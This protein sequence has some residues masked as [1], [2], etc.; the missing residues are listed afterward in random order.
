M[1]SF[2]TPAAFGISPNALWLAALLCALVPGSGSA[3]TPASPQGQPHAPRA[4][5]TSP[6]PDSVNQP[7]TGDLAGL[8]TLAE[9]SNPRL[10]ASE[11]RLRAANARIGPA[12][13]RPDPSLMAGV[14]NLPISDPSFSREM[15]TMTMVGVMQTVPY[16]GKLPL[17]KLAAERQR[18]AQEAALL[19]TQRGVEYDVRAAYY[20][21]VFLDKAIDVVARNQQVLGDFTRVAEASYSTGNA[22]QADVINV[23]MEATRLAEQAVTLT[24]RRRSALASLNAILDRPG[25]TAVSDTRLPDRIVRAAVADSAQN[26]RFVSAALGARAADSP[27]RALEDVQA[28]AS[29]ESPAL[30]E[31]EQL[32]AAQQA[33]VGFAQREHLPDFSL[34]LQYGQRSGRSDMVSATV[35][36]PIPLQK[37]SKQDQ[38]VA[39]AGAELSALQGD[40]SN[41]R[42][43]LRAE[44]TRL[45][46]E[47][48]RQRAQLALYVKAMLPQAHASLAS[49]TASYQAGR[50][51]FSAL[52]DSQAILFTYETEYFRQ[53]S[54]FAKTLAELERVVGSGVLK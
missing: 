29:L 14:V 2:R 22:Q 43:E 4:A 17:L 54:D 53:L 47:L 50:S 24:E 38:V 30:R 6:A 41:R 45:Y 20:Q 52:L 46:S 35:S 1:H 40:Q 44:V 42:N 5:I 19:A 7:S 49:T 15:M 48:E 13:S 28:L 51:A 37:H 34:S 12:A 11:A 9:K 32:I 25:E 27:L 39:E 8:L 3:Q 21:L 16:P 10:R 33:R 18:D 31:Q 36:V 26:I 23:R